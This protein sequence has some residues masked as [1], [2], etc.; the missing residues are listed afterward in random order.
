MKIWNALRNSVVSMINLKW[1]IYLAAGLFGF[2]VSSPASAR[3][4]S[5]YEGAKSLFESQFPGLS[6]DHQWSGPIAAAGSTPSQKNVLFQQ[7]GS[8]MELKVCK[9]GFCVAVPI[10]KV[11]TNGRGLSLTLNTPT[12][13]GNN[14]VQ[15]DDPSVLS[16]PT[17][18]RLSRS[19]D[20]L[21]VRSSLFS[22]AVK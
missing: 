15:V 12:L 7:V 14:L 18:V 9:F 20:G 1:Q 16:K 3:C 4:S 2:L 8:G 22:G 13:K 6:V 10:L 11:C 17:Q 5:S 21:N 19:G